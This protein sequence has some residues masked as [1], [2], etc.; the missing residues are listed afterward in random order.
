MDF[1]LFLDRYCH[2]ASINTQNPDST[3]IPSPASFTDR[4]S[5]FPFTEQE[6]SNICL[7]TALVIATA[8]RNLPYPNPYGTQALEISPMTSGSG[9]SSEGL[10]RKY[11]RTIPYFACCAMQSCYS[12]LMILHKIRACLATDRLATCY[13]LL[14]KPEPAS[15]VSDAERLIEE[16][17]HGVESLG[18]CLKS[19]IIFEGVGGMGHEIEHSYL[20]AFPE[21]S[22][23]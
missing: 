8:F 3:A 19:D 6:S 18:I 21:C 15:E 13:H 23:F 20:A 11:P 10:V 17:R 16:L 9:I 12:M 1:P 7:K 14:S 2:I 22:E 5:F 4:N